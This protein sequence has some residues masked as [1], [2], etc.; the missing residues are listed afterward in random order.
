MLNPTIEWR[1]L[2][3]RRCL[4]LRFEGHLSSEDAQRA[5]TTLSSMVGKHEGKLTMVWECTQMGGFDT[6]A[7]EAWQVFIKS[8]KLKIEAIHLISNN[9]AIRS[10][11]RVVGIF[12]GIKVVTWAGLDEFRTQG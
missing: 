2:R 5:I 4:F 12:A 8:I 7:R 6:E 9:V 10:G 11:A 3:N 1:D